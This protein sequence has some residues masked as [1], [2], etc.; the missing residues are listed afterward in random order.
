MVALDADPISLKE[1]DRA[2]GT[3]GVETVAAPFSMLITN[4]VQVGQFDLIYST[5]L[6]DYLNK[7]TGRRLVST[8]FR[9]LN[10]GGKLVV[11]NFM[12]GIRDVG[13]MEAFMDWKLIYRNRQDMVDLTMEVSESEIRDV[14]LFAEDSRNIIFVEVT[15]I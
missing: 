13:Y 2:Y 7:S 11:A 8:L 6:F 4:R 5:G 3:Y 15:K 14:T 9:M 1:V 10:P 12:P